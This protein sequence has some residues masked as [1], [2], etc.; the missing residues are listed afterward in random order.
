VR[1]EGY[2][3]ADIYSITFLQTPE[4]R[5]AVLLASTAPKVVIPEP[6]V[7]IPPVEE[8]EKEKDF[9]DPILQLQKEL[10][11]VT[12]LKGRVM[13]ENSA[14]PLGATI[15]LTDNTTNTIITQI[16]SSS[17]TGDFQ[18]TIPHG[19]NYGVS[20][21]R[22]GYLFNSINFNL[23]QFAEYQEID[24]SILMVKAEVGS[25]AVLKNIFFDTGK[26]DL[27]QE[28]VSE[29]ENIFE[30][31][32][33]NPN[34]KVQINGHTDNTGDDSTNKV[35]SLK[36]ASSVVNHLIEKGISQ[37]RL[38]AVGFGEERPLVSNDDEMDGREINRRTE[39]EITEVGQEG[40]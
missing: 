20:T 36:R 40:N 31:L 25:R 1:E 29:L 14:A 4:E 3:A 26:S 5:D 18:L 10:K 9:V 27:K 24:A 37:T 17:A 39:I 22:A 30:L 32:E 8:E 28:S 11:I 15:T 38:T 6:E 12:V 19:G 7:E 33:S 23:P 16:K 21:E 35:L 2:G 34:L 13:D